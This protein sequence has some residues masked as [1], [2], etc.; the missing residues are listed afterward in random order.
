MAEKV[1]GPDW[2]VAR[3]RECGYG[4]RW[5]QVREHLEQWVSETG[6]LRPQLLFDA[7]CKCVARE[8]REA[9]DLRERVARLEAITEKQAQTIGR[10]QRANSEA[11]GRAQRS[12]V[13]FGRC[14]TEWLHMESVLT[15][16][17]SGKRPLF[18]EGG[19]GG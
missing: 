2:A 13:F 16:L 14:S 18:G 15:A 1:E 7:A 17:E 10:L 8:E 12:L 6:A 5:K 9:A 4:E 19:A 11:L 3:L